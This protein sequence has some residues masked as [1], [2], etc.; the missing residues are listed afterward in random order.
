VI[1]R[2]LTEPGDDILSLLASASIGEDSLSRAELQNMAVMLAFA[3]VD[4]TRNQLGLGLSMFMAS[5]EQWE[6]LAADPSLDMAASNECMRTR[7][8]ITW[9]SREAI[10]D[11]EF[12]GLEIKSGTTLHLFSESAGTDPAAFPN[13][14]FNITVPRERNF[15]FGAGMHVCLGQMVAKNDMAVAYRLLSQRIKSP[16]I[17]G[18]P[19]SLPDSGNTGWVYLPI[20]FEKR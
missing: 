3:G 5:P 1:E 14:E 6:F 8:T 7:P 9:V 20:A 2:R 12:K 4:T 13:A 15:G 17:Q 18:T 16:R 11:F 19:V 10:E